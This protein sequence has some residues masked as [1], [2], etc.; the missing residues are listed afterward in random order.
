MANQENK[1]ERAKLVIQ[2]QGYEMEC[3]KR[4]GGH[5]FLPYGNGQKEKVI[6]YMEIEGSN[7]KIK[8]K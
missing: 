1:R 2:G 4:K 7:K 3:M 8:L 6:W 5:Y